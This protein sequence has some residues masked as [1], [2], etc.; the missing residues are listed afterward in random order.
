MDIFLR[1]FRAPPRLTIIAYRPRNCRIATAH[2]RLTIAPSSPYYSPDV[3]GISIAWSSSLG[4]T[5]GLQQQITRAPNDYIS[6]YMPGLHHWGEL[7]Y[8][9]IIYKI[10]FHSVT[11]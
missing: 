6:V 5:I 4:L 2:L 7:L 1:Q 11:A 9:N 10:S 8:Y 3:F